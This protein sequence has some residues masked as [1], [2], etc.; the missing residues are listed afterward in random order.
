MEK[1][2]VVKHNAVVEARYHLTVTEARI[3]TFLTSKV[4][5]DDEDFKLHTAS[6]GELLELLKLGKDNYSAL[7]EAI[8]RLMGRVIFIK[9]PDGKELKTHFVS[10]C[11]YDPATSTISLNHDPSMKPYFLQLKENFTKYQLEN[12]LSLK[13]FYSIR[14]YELC[15]QYQV[16]GERTITIADL[17]EILDIDKKKYK[18]YAHFRTRILE[19]AEREINE[20]T[21]ISIKFEGIKFG[22]TTNKIKFFIKENQKKADPVKHYVP[23]RGEAVTTA[24]YE[25]IKRQED[26]ARYEKVMEGLR[27]AFKGLP[28]AEQ[29]AYLTQPNLFTLGGEEGRFDRAVTAWATAEGLWEADAVT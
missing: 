9:Q 19:V 7:S 11:E 2:L 25:A 10:R 28:E 5:K 1:A 26:D 27:E 13:S 4:Q 22:K 12:V 18:Q 15:K 17:R 29:Q 23:K 21:D 24:D 16:I 6:V 8:D 3:I 14:I 20:K